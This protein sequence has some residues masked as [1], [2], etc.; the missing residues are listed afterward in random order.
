M[1]GVNTG[2]QMHYDS[3]LIPDEFG[4]N[5]NDSLAG[6]LGLTG[7]EGCYMFFSRMDEDY[8]QIF[9]ERLQNDARTYSERSKDT[10]VNDSTSNRIFAD[11]DVSIWYVQGRVTT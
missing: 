11:G 10:L 7:G 1:F 6:A 9:F 4:Y 8:H 2:P 3:S 5:G